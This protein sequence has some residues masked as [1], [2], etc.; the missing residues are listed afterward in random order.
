MYVRINRH[1]LRFGVHLVID[2]FRVS[3]TKK[4]TGIPRGCEEI[5]P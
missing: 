3:C 4:G 1:E 5:C 2:K